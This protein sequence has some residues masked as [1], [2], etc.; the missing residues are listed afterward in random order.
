ML[1]ADGGPDDCELL[2]RMADDACEGSAGREAWG[3][4]YERHAKYVHGKCIAAHSKLI[5]IGNVAAAVNDTFLRAYEKAA[6]FRLSG[7]PA[8][9]QERIA[10]AWLLR[11]NE[12][13][14]RDHFRNSPK[15]VFAEDPE[16]E[17][18]EDAREETE[19]SSVEL[20]SA[21]STLVE[22]GLKQLSD[23]EQRVLR[24]TVF[25]YV[26]GARYQRMPHAAMASL[27]KELNTTPSNI[28]QIR[29]R[30][31]ETLR[32]YILARS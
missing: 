10:R 17:D 30:A 29:V 22:E 4:F 21:K 11:I 16:L 25:W 7:S 19:K 1:P 26:P 27:A 15:I 12:N 18:G 31:L 13:I 24:A 6:T 3:V 8:E 14:V 32:Q 5:G 9:D 23:R 28:R 20:P 2:R